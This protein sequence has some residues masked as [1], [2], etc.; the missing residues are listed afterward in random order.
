MLAL[1]ELQGAFRDALLDGS[2]RR[3][4]REID[5]R[6]VGAAGALAIY[7]NHLRLSLTAALRTTFPVVCRLVDERFFGFAA[8]AYIQANP[9]AGPCLAEYGGSFADFLAGFAPCRGLPY[10]ADVARLEWAL[11]LAQIAPHAPRLDRAALADVPANALPGLR[12]TFDPAV[13]LLASSYPVDRIWRANQEPLAGIV[14]LAGACRIEVRRD[15]TGPVLEALE[16]ASF[17][18][19]QAMYRGLPLGV[20]AEAA[21][22]TDPMFDL[23]L[24]LGR[25]IQHDVFSSFTIEPQERSQ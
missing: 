1:P 22:N 24:E 20:A 4:L 23:A 9:P 10:L 19:R 25:M 6:G 18:F 12:F 3:I 17:V 2:A 8:H 15:A 5:G 14:E 13:R 16:P 11:N 21:A 7:R